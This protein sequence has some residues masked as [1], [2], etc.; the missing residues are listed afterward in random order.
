MVRVTELRLKNFRSFGAGPD[1]TGQ[2]I[3]FAEPICFLVGE[4]NVG[5]SNVLSALRECVNYALGVGASPADYHLKNPRLEMR[6]GMRVEFDDIDYE[7]MERILLIK[8][9]KPRSVIRS[10]LRMLIPSCEISSVQSARSRAVSIEIQGRPGS[11]NFLFPLPSPD[12]RQPTSSLPLETF[13]EYC[14]SFPEAEKVE[15]VLRKGGH[16]PSTTS[17]NLGS[18]IGNLIGS[19][20]GPRLAVFE[21]VRLRPR[22]V[23]QPTTQSFDGSRVADVLH[24]LKNGDRG[25]RL[26]YKRIQEVF[27]E[28]FPNL[29]LEVTGQT[30]SPQIV[31][32]QPETGLEVDLDRSGAGIGQVVTLLAHMVNAHGM[33]FAV[34]TPE[35]NLHPHGLRTLLLFF[36][37]VASSNQLIL[38]THSPIVIPPERL[39]A[40]AAIR[41]FGGKSRVYQMTPETLTAVEKEK[42]RHLLGAEARELM[43][44][45]KAIFVEGDTDVGALPILLRAVSC[46]LDKEGISLVTM[47]GKHFAKFTKIAKALG[48]PYSVVCDRDALEN[49]EAGVTGP[50]GRVACSV[51]LSQLHELGLVTFGQ[52]R[53]ALRTARAKGKQTHAP[54]YAPE[55]VARLRAAAARHRVFVWPSDLEGVLEA[56]LP[57][58]KVR[59][60]NQGTRSKVIRGR[61]LATA[62]IQMGPLPPNLASTLKRISRMRAKGEHPPA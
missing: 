9:D 62:L 43:F 56:L 16:D 5:K 36:E 61:A 40:V 4:N 10:A 47:D 14:R 54:S 55:V 51:V 30:Q 1:G 23:G 59:E 27:S 41:F 24:T 49:L 52:I 13:I 60:I 8:A 39:G 26:S 35:L 46:D 44:A 29:K 7:L 3:T 15:S 28:T 50:D 19:V 20:A 17:I 33:V 42:L 11:G 22:G 18:D 32:E 25:Q 45:R 58:E 31:V 21:E 48:I 38:A 2:R 57:A 34:D 12:G 6:L 53:S 37:S